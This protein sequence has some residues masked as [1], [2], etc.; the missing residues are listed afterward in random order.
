MA[1]PYDNGK[2]ARIALLDGRAK[3]LQK[4]QIAGAK[5]FFTWPSKEPYLIGSRCRACGDYSFPKAF[6]CRNPNCDKTKGVEEVLLSRRGK[7]WS[8]TIQYY[9]APAPFV[10]PEPFVPYGIGE[11]ELPE[12][13]KVVGMLSGCDPEKDLELGMEM[14]LVVEKLYEDDHGNEVVT[15]KFKPV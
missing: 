4:K 6:I 1:S 9:P 12:G 3:V 14:E 11:V 7:L 13:L 10:A 5:G 2:L 15:W 8:Y